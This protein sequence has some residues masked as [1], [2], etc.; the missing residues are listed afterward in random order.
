[1][2]GN[3]KAKLL[4]E[5]GRA[6]IGILPSILKEMTNRPKSRH[7]YSSEQQQQ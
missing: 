1:L 6:T 2:H 7:F 4:E 3:A 5:N